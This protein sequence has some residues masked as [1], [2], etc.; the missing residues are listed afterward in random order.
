MWPQFR[1]I[2]EKGVTI[3]NSKDCDK[4]Y[5]KISKVPS[6]VRVV[7]SQMV[8]AEDLNRENFCYVSTFLLAPSPPG[9]PAEMVGGVLRG[10]GRTEEAMGR[11]REGGGEKKRG[12]S[13]A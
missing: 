9:A 8:C 5:H 3:L 13:L 4:L 10:E 12:G 7:D 11:E 2:Q 6:L 1:S